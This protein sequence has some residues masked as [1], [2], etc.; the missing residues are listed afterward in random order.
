MYKLL[1]KMNF[2]LPTISPKKLTKVFLA[3]KSSPI[4]PPIPCML[5][6]AVQ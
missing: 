4:R 5:N 3:Q 1:R 6:Q 2:A